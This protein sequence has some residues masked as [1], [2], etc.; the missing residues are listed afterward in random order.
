MWPGAPPASMQGRGPGNSS[1]RANRPAKISGMAEA[2]IPKRTMI[3]H[4]HNLARKRRAYGWQSVKRT[5]YRVVDGRDGRETS[6]I[7]GGGSEVFGQCAVGQR[8]REVQPP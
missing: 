2:R 6:P 1:P 7:S 3:R 4:S 8:F 5:G